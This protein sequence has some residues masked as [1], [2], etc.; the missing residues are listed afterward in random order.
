ML[1]KRRAAR[2]RRA[3]RVSSNRPRTRRRRRAGRRDRAAVGI[4]SRRR[5]RAGCRASRRWRPFWRS[6]SPRSA[7][8]SPTASAARRRPSRPCRRSC[9]TGSRASY[10]QAAALTDGGAAPGHGRARRRLH[11]RRRDQRVLRAEVR[12]PARVH[13]GGRV[14][15]HRGPGAVRA[16][17]DLHRAIP[18][19]LVRRPVDHSLDA[20]GHQPQPRGGRPAGGGDHLPAARPDHRHERPAARHRVGRLPGRRVP[21]PAHQRGGDRRQVQRGHRSRPAAGARPDPGRAPGLVPVAAHPSGGLAGGLVHRRVA[22]AGQ[23]A[24]PRLRA[25]DAAAVRFA[26]AADG[27]RGRDGGLAGAA[28]RGRRL[29]ARHDRR[30]I[31]P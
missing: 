15:G 31:R 9:S 2:C 26:R 12:H 6:S 1:R 23:G 28:G 3:D 16:A 24:G 22:E 8:A 10:A 18:G 11:R 21:G 7:S 20:L 29:P 30:G 4:A 14:P 27:R 5:A 13:G 17:V 25:T 19:D